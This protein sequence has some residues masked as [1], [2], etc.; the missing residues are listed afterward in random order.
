MDSINI[1]RNIGEL[2]KKNG[3]TQEELAT[4]I[5]VTKASVSKWE[6]G[7]SMPDI[8][9]LPLLASYFDVTVD[10]L[11]GY[12]PQLSKEQIQAVYK[13]FS[14]AFSKEPFEE[15]FLRSEAYVKKYYSC[16]RFLSQVCVLWMNH[17][18]M[19][20][21]AERQQEIL[22]KI[23]ALC[24]HIIDNCDNSIIC[25]DALIMRAGINLQM[26]KPE[27]VIDDLEEL[28]NPNRLLNQND[29]LLIQ[30]Y[31]MK[32]DKEKADRFVQIS[33]YVH[34]LTIVSD[35]VQFVGIHGSD[36]RLCMETMK[37]TDKLIEAY[38]LDKLSQ[39][40]V[41][42]Y[43]YQMAAVLCTYGEQNEAVSRLDKY[44]RLVVDMLEHT[45]RLHGDSYFDK[46]DSCFEDFELGSQ[47]VRDKKLVMES[48]IAE[49]D[50]PI[51]A[52]LKEMVEYKNIQIM[53]DSAKHRI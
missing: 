19:A 24:S 34:L 43:Q 48:A 40:V 41:A 4:F 2:R 15:V 35:A 11:L 26:G 42:G 1:G 20:E 49:L 9:L 52:G 31:T 46:L 47:L 39:H 18:M 13:D 25:S 51:F 6:N 16:Y 50:N 3:V 12:E 22:K 38:S 8:L 27:V 44:A 45:P 36:K 10:K 5:G 28:I 29:S 37:R 30:A 7:Q 17:F 21:S 23:E 32:G 53:M 33:M 14:K